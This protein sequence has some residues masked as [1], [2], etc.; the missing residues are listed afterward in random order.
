MLLKM[1]SCLTM[2]LL[3]LGMSWNGYVFNMQIRRRHIYQQ[4]LVP[5]TPEHNDKKSLRWTHTTVATL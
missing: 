2:L 4:M 1:L 5:P 3:S